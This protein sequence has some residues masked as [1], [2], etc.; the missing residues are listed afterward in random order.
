MHKSNHEK[1]S[2]SLAGAHL[3]QMRGGYFVLIVNAD[4]FLSACFIPIS[5]TSGGTSEPDRS[6][7]SLGESKCL[8]GWES[9][10]MRSP[11]VDANLSATEQMKVL[12]TREGGKRKLLITEIFSATKNEARAKDC[13]TTH[14]SSTFGERSG[15]IDKGQQRQRPANLDL[16]HAVEQGAIVHKG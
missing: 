10:C 16:L 6:Q 8:F 2:R 4:S 3:S 13:W 15:W 7:R 11:L 14:F 5:C 9:I 12:V 1:A